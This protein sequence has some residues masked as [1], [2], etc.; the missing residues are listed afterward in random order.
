MH[1]FYSILWD[2]PL[3]IWWNGKLSLE[4]VTLRIHFETGGGIGRR[5]SQA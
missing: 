4:M 5:K 3:N 2:W 1:R